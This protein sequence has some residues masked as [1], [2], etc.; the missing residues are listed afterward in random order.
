MEDWIAIPIL[1]TIFV[2]PLALILYYK[3]RRLKFEA[4]IQSKGN[5]SAELAALAEKME[6]R[7]D[8]LEQI[9]DTE[10]PGWRKRHHEH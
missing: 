2:M 9:L 10:A 1:F 6:K 7:I 5:Y 3:E 8:A 4:Q